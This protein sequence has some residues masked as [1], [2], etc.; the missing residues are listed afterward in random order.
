MH[1]D[2][3]EIENAI[4]TYPDMSKHIRGGIQFDS[5]IT[6]RENLARA[7]KR[8]QLWMPATADKNW[9]CPEIIPDNTARAFVIQGPKY[10]GEFGGDDMFGIYWEYVPSARGSKLYRWMQPSAAQDAK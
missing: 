3:R 8:Q 10:E 6:K 4:V 2:N 1:F 9:F 7:Y 5:P